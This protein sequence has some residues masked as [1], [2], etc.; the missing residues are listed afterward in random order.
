MV[1]ACLVV[2]ALAACG[3]RTPGASESAPP[4]PADAAVADAAPPADF[5]AADA[6]PP[7]PTADASLAEIGIAP[8]QAVVARFLTCPGV[9]EASKQQMTEAARRWHDEAEKSQERREELA[10]ACLEIA[11]MTE[12]ML[13]QAGC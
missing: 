11:R 12:E 6:A 4:A 1:R 13:L 2:L 7:G 9:P 8:C 10:A 5:S 3:S